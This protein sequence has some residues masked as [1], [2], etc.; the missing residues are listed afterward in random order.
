MNPTRTLARA[1]ISLS[2]ALLTLIL[3]PKFFESTLTFELSIGAGIVAIGSFVLLYNFGRDINITKLL[4][5]L[6]IGLTIYVFGT[7]VLMNIDRSRSFYVLVWSENVKS[8]EEIADLVTQQFGGVEISELHQR[9][10]EQ[11]KRGLL[12]EDQG[13]YSLTKLGNV[14]LSTSRILAKIFS[15][16]AFQQIESEANSK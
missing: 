6:L 12:V 5:G 16:K 11:V 7:T 3:V 14:T 15:L 9:L 4:A 8:E 10:L 13:K 2:T 1:T